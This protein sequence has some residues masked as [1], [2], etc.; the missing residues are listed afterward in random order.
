M[1][2][3]LSKKEKPAG[4]LLIF[5]KGPSKGGP[6]SGQSDADDTGDT[7]ESEPDVPADFEDYAAQALP[8]LEGEPERMHALWKAMQACMKAGMGGMGG[9]KESY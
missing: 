8:E 1:A 6:A 9:K 2:A 5:G 4:A 3:T 7:E